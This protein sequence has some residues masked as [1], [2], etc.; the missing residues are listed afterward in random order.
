MESTLIGGV[1]VVPLIMGLVEIAK[2][3]FGLPGTYAA[4]LS[5]GLGTAISLG[6]W[7]AHTHGAAADPFQATIGGL[8]LGLS[9][10]GLY[11]VAHA[12]TTR[13]EPPPH[14]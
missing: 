8:A 6:A 4:L 12:V 7:A 2:R 3:A 1:A 14:G 10:S 11:S 13:K 5:A 9:A